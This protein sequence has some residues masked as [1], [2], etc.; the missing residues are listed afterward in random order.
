MKLLFA[1]GYNDDGQCGRAVRKERK[2]FDLPSVV[3]F[4]DPLI[5]IRCVSAGSRH[6]LAL[7][8][9][10]KV[11]S[12]GWG[13]VGQLGLGDFHSTSHP[14]VVPN[15]SDII[16]ISA[17]GMHSACIDKYYR[18]YA[19]GG[20]SNG[21]LGLGKG[22][23][24]GPES[25]VHTPH[26]V[27]FEAEDMEQRTEPFRVK[28]IS[29]GGMHTA[30]VGLNGELYCWG[31]ADSGQIGFST[32]YLDFVPAVYYPKEVPGLPYPAI[33]VACGSFYTLVLTTRNVVYAMGK[34]DYGCLGT[35]VEITNM[36]IG[37]ETPTLVQAL[38]RR[39]VTNITA[40]GWHSFFITEEGELYACGK[41]EYG[42]LGLGSESSRLEPV[43]V[44]TAADDVRLCRIVQVSAGGSHTV[45]RDENHHVFSTG[46]TDGGRCGYGRVT[47]D[48]INVGRDITGNF[49]KGGA[50]MKVSQVSA[51]GAHTL[52]LAEYEDEDSA[53]FAHVVKVY[54][55]TLE[56]RK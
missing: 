37:V 41:G 55:D 34:E 21:Q 25:A 8:E 54:Q 23:G 16:E 27:E 42:R 19:W 13:R 14:T 6:S 26:L 51:G 31:K 11:F 5:R 45:W 50:G 43:A 4:L 17:G 44:T 36:A 18:C 49:F 30:S 22:F 46:R 56:S 48:R 29:C 38:T 52:V 24:E 33:D 10:G 47:S 3:K 32:W 2:G 53:D 35:G 39:A 9:D 12:W 28:R 15:L 7:T 1:F 20:N 40:G